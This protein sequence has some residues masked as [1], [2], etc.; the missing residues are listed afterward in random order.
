M[1]KYIGQMTFSSGQVRCYNIPDHGY[2]VLFFAHMELLH[3][4]IIVQL[5]SEQ[6]AY[7][8]INTHVLMDGVFE[9]IS[10]V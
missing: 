7:T 3:S 6:V 10:D 8:T 2:Y 4:S 9:V 5:I 1:V